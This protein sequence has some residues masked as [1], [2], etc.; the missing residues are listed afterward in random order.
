MCRFICSLSGDP[1][2]YKICSAITFWDVCYLKGLTFGESS[3]APSMLQS[4]TPSL[5]LCCIIIPATVSS[6]LYLWRQ[7]QPCSGSAGYSALHIFLSAIVSLTYFYFALHLC[8]L[9]FLFRTIMVFSLPCVSCP[10]VLLL[11][12]PV[13]ASLCPSLTLLHLSLSLSFC[14]VYLPAEPWGKNML[15]STSLAGV[16]VCVCMCVYTV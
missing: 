14:S 12:L 15:A 5:V 8:S 3:L 9:F 16:C 1:S 11:I 7:T 13:L 10:L 6:L 4:L 2:D